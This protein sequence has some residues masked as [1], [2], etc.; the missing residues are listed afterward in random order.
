VDDVLRLSKFLKPKKQL[1]DQIRAEI[2]SGSVPN[3][4]WQFVKVSLQER[5]S[6]ESLVTDYNIEGQRYRKL[7]RKHRGY[8]E[9]AC[10]QQRPPLSS[11]CSKTRT[12]RKEQ[13]CENKTEIFSSCKVSMKSAEPLI[14]EAKPKNR[15]RSNLQYWDGS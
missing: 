12:P 13:N 11:R 9:R 7:R 10:G 4:F 2:G 1:A 8:T 3:E 14:R 15:M 6:G 5:R